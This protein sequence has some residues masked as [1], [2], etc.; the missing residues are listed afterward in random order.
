[1]RSASKVSVVVRAAD[2]KV[3]IAGTPTPTRE[4]K[5]REGEQF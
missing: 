1:M 2:E 4:I 3:R 5:K